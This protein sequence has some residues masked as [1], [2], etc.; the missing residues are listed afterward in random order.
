MSAT[1]IFQ[2]S[3]DEPFTL[4]KLNA[5]FENIVAA[6]NA[7]AADQMLQLG[8]VPGGAGNYV[9]VSGGQ[10]Y[11]QVGVPSLLI[12]PPTG[13][14]YLAVSMGDQ[15]TTTSFGVVRQAAASANVAGAP[16]ASYV[17]AEVQAILTELRDLKDKLRTAG[18]LAA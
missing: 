15:A 18:V 4:V 14:A 13:P 8:A 9:P 7:L 10:F 5:N 12:G 2:F 3:D 6:I 17:Q 16:G 11:G 1:V